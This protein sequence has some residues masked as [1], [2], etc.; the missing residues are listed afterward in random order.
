MTLPS[1]NT[2]NLNYDDEWKILWIEML[3]P[4]RPCFTI[5]NL[6]DFK[7]AYHWIRQ[8]YDDSNLDVRY[9]V[10]TSQVPGIHNLGGDLQLFVKLIT[11]QDREGLQ[12][13]ANLCIE[14]QY[15]RYSSLGRPFFT[16]TLLTGDALG[17][18]YECALT[19]D[20]IIAENTANIGLPESRFNMFPG[21]GAFS[22]LPL[23]VRPEKV[24]EIICSGEIYPTKEIHAINGID[25]VCDA[26]HGRDAVLQ[27]VKEHDKKFTSRALMQ[28]AKRVHDAVSKSE[29]QQITD[30][31]VEAALRLSK[32]DIRMMR[33][34]A[35]M[36]DR[37][38]KQMMAS[39]DRKSYVLADTE[40]ET[41]RLRDQASLF[42]EETRSIFKTIGLKKGMHC[43]DV[44]FGPGDA[45][46][47]MGEFIGEEG[48]ITGLETNE[49]MGRQVLAEI[50]KESGPTFTFI[51]A[52]IENDN[53]IGNETFDLSFARFLLIH[54]DDPIDALKRMWNWT[55]KDGHILIMDYDFRSMDA[56]P[57]LRPVTHLRN[58]IDAVFL[59]AS[60]DPRLGAKLPA[61]FEEA[62]IGRPDGL[63]VFSSIK[64]TVDFKQLLRATHE[65]F[66]PRAIS[67]G[68]TTQD[69]AD[70]FYHDLEALPDSLSNYL[71]LPLVVGAWKKK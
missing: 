47:L 43:L 2:L 14:D 17:G 34:I 45:S 46:R 13:Y 36:Q 15:L 22:L 1:F 29:M 5:E 19:D 42:E 56:F 69:E 31:W 55:K 26:G 41:Q 37:Q 71:M 30:F 61:F 21:M 39:R 32:D 27:F 65:S 62:G 63:E 58:L 24:D 44:G 18:G 33:T 53:G 57:P 54:L 16:I 7:N 40:A 68:I 8:Q 3:H 50:G 60:L 52:S 67:V 64:Q 49:R 59:D 4:E 12:F 48:E 10:T 6:T 11:E 23:R 9:L 28:Q 70:Q 25:I 35:Y 51:S 20:V 66:L 38:L